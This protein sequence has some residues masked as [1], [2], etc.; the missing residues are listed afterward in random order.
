[1]NIFFLYTHPIQY[2]A[3]LQILLSQQDEFHSTVLYC[4][5]TSAGYF[6]AEFGQRLKWDT[7]LTEGY[8]HR[9]LPNSGFSFSIRHLLKKRDVDILVVHGWGYATAWIAILIA[10]LRGIEVWLRAETPLIHEVRKGR[11][12]SILRRLVIGQFLFRLVDKFLYIG[13]QNRKFYQY[14]GI[15]EARLIFAPYSVNNQFFGEA[16]ARL[17]P[18]RN[19]NRET[20]GIPSDAKV[21]LYCGKLITKKR[22]MD[23]LQAFH[24]LGSTGG[25]YL[26]FVGDGELRPEMEAFIERNRIRNVLITGFIN[27]SVIPMY[28]SIAD[29]FVMCSDLGETW[30]LSTNEAMN[31]GLPVVISDQT[32]NFEDLV[33]GNG[34]VFSTGNI[35]DLSAKIG[36]MLA[37]TSAELNRMG[38]ASKALISQYSY[39]NVVAGIKS[40]IKSRN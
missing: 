25:A 14:Y 32:G 10:K 16:A 28:Y 19:N 20:L 3:P 34:Y 36:K 5:D 13:E 39:E 31:F 35:A 33:K 15:E 23:L 1:M 2:F 18:A 6:D 4:K 30:G 27:Q 40:G 26:I 37:M 24:Q 29:L 38:E 22:P 17:A 11:I 7:V 21:I 8:P 9:F 12:S